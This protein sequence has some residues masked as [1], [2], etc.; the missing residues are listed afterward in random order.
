MTPLG[1]REPGVVGA[2]LADADSWCGVIVDGHHVHPASLRVAIAAKARGK[3]L[4][5][6]DAMPPVGSDHP[7]FVLHGETIIA[8]DG[9][10]QTAQGVLAGSALD[11]AGAVR[12]AVQM[13][14][15][16]LDEV[17]RMASTYPADFLGLGASHGRIA[18]GYQADLVAMDD[19]YRV[20]QSWIGGAGKRCE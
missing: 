8:K 3:V 11:M 2:A 5:V 13:L 10:C 18:A 16:P 7:D 15:L 1:S 17:V 6:T 4:L 9:I 14:G 20:Q 19:N 12:N